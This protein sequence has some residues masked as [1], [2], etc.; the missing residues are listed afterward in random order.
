[1]PQRYQILSL[2]TRP[3]SYQSYLWRCPCSL[4][5]YQS[6]FFQ[7][8]ISIY[9]SISNR[10]SFFRLTFCQDIMYDLLYGD[11]ILGACHWKH[12]RFIHA[13]I[14]IRKSYLCQ[15]MERAASWMIVA[16]G[17]QN[18]IFEYSVKE[19]QLVSNHVHLPKMT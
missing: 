17:C 3:R 13:R 11:W 19:L 12:K 2:L 1:M 18:Y 15:L 16:R 10:N 6:K 7:A 14:Y 4:L 8:I 9:L 5:I